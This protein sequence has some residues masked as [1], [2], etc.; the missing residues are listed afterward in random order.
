[1]YYECKLFSGKHFVFEEVCDLNPL[2]TILKMSAKM[3]L[4]VFILSLN[5][6]V[7]LTCESE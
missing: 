1:M 4:K 3:L 2:Y 7:Q 6:D 5:Q